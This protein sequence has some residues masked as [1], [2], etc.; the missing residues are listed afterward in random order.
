V[1][2]ASTNKTAIKSLPKVFMLSPFE[3]SQLFESELDLQ[4]IYAHRGC[5][6]FG[7]NGSAAFH[8]NQPHMVMPNTKLAIKP[9]PLTIEAQTDVLTFK[10]IPAM[11]K[12]M[13]I[14]AMMQHSTDMMAVNLATN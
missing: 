11:P 9:I 4:Q 6:T 3:L 5:L 7:A 2:H 13:P 1:E 10:A 8:E 12:I 14:G